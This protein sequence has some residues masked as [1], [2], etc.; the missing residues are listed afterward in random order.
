M[1]VLTCEFW[2]DTYR[3]LWASYEFLKKM[4][5]PFSH[6]TINNIKTNES[7]SLRFDELEKR[8]NEDAEGVLRIAKK[9][10]NHHADLITRHQAAEPK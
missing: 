5:G 1:P 6:C 3:N 10:V 4:A 8:M 7:I 9:A 2:G